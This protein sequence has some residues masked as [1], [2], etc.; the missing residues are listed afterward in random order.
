MRDV[1]SLISSKAAM[2]RSD[3]AAPLLMSPGR[4]DGTICQDT[5][6]P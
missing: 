1:F 2:T 5:P 4:I 3:L 6:W